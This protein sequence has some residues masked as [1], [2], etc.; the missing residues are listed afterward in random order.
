MIPTGDQVGGALRAIL[1]TAGGY[2]VAK[3]WITPDN[4]GA[5]SAVAVAAV[6]G[7]WSAWTNRPIKIA[8]PQQQAQ[9]AI[10]AALK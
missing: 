7:G 5:L 2:A 1:A 9:N 8:T 10:S 6:I 3:G 4:W